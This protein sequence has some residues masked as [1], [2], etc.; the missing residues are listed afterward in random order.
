MGTTEP[1]VDA[2]EVARFLG[3]AKVTVY[4]LAKRGQIPSVKIG[5]FRRFRLSEI[6]AAVYTQGP[7]PSGGAA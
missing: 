6:E 7:T 5:R 4:E 3:L 1:F 2:R